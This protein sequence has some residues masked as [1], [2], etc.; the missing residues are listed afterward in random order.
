MN[1]ARLKESLGCRFRIRPAP[2]VVDERGLAHPA[3][4]TWIV[5]AVEPDG[6]RLIGISSSYAPLV[7]W[8]HIVERLS[9][10][11]A[12]TDQNGE[13]F[14]LLKSQVIF[15][16]RGVRF[17]PLLR[18]LMA[19]KLRRPSRTNPIVNPV[20]DT[21]SKGTDASALLAIGFVALA[22]LGRRWSSEHGL[23]LAERR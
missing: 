20:A 5:T 10:P 13:A 9:N 18:P 7:P 11:V 6:L 8:D 2:V 16:R 4:D 12:Q 14:L 23:K 17:E 19:P 3:D 1:R 15:D 21:P 22:A